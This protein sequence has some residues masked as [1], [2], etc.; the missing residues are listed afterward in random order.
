[1]TRAAAL[2]WLGS[3]LACDGGGPCDAAA[4]EPLTLTIGEGENDYRRL[5]QGSQ[6]TRIH[7]PQGGQHVYVALRATGIAPGGY[8]LLKPDA[9]PRTRVQVVVG[10]TDAVIAESQ[11]RAP[12]SGDPSGAEI[13][14]IR[15]VLDGGFTRVSDTG[16]EP[17]PEGAT[18]TRLHAEVVDRCGT[19]I[20]ATLDIQL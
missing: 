6:M 19:T 11:V 15:T 9:A 17:A 20:E 18:A 12:W 5:A 7:G 10:E 2:L 8:N 1:M 3:L 4:K 16:G 13:A 14:G